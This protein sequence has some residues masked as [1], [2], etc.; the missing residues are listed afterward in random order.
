MSASGLQSPTAT[1]HAASAQ[2][3]DETAMLSTLREK[4][5]IP[6]E[7]EWVRAGDRRRRNEGEEIREMR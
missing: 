1:T 4:V 2:K 7:S 5:S 6:A 3:L